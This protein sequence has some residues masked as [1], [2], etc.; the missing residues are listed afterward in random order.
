MT[1]RRITAGTSI[2]SRAMLW[3]ALGIYI[4][5]A[6]C[7]MFHHE[8]WGDELHSWNM[9]KNSNTFWEL[10][11]NRR[12]EGHPHVWYIILWLITRFTHDPAYMQVVHLCIAVL[13]VVLILFYA[14]FKTCVKILIPFGY[15]FIF[16]YAI[17]S[18]N[19]A[20]GI[21]AGLL[22]CI[23]LNKEFK[24]KFLLYYA[25]LLLMSY[26]HLLALV[27]AGSIHVYFLLSL[28]DVTKRQRKMLHFALGAIIFLSAAYC[29]KPP[30]NSDLG[31]ASLMHNWNTDRLVI[32]MQS[33]LRA[34]VPIPAWWEYH[35]WN[36]ECFIA[37]HDRFHFMKGVSPVLALGFI[38]IGV[39]LLKADRKS[40]I[41][42]LVNFAAIFVI[43]NIYP[44]TTLRYT[45]FIF[46][47]FIVAAWLHHRSVPF[48]GNRNRIFVLLLSLQIIAGAIIISKDLQLPFS[49]DYKIKA[50][51]DHV[52]AGQ[53]VVTDYWGLIA[54]NAYTDKP[55]YCIDLEK[56]H[57]FIVWGA[58]M[59]SMREK[60]H[61]YYTGVHTIFQQENVH[62]IYLVSNS[63]PQALMGIDKKL[64]AGYHVA[65]VEQ[66]ANAI[67]K[68]SNLYLYRISKE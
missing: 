8:L 57:T 5:V 29:I 23:V 50:M 63:S 68:W 59:V 66:Q 18:R 47:G 4:V 48:S 38:L 25:L 10:L 67:E 2:S 6:C 58:D 39:Y 22:L 19:Y 13:S 52:P 3:M 46:V 60:L 17:L 7:T 30:G 14:P 43:G 24:C 21:L 26:T 45:G 37:L 34:F 49:N 65:V 1:E 62:V 16:E 27:L 61:R 51:L 20:P 64:F 28:R 53:K 36:S 35:C 12:Y 32:G 55:W 31:L 56:E 9:A 41:L 33:P 11:Q 54:A 42:F 40:V 15:F 44:L